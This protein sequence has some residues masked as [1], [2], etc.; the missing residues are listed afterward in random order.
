ML[1]QCDRRQ[2]KRLARLMIFSV[3]PP[4]SG[5]MATMQTRGSILPL[6][7]T[8]ALVLTGVVTGC[9]APQEPSL[10]QTVITDPTPPGAEEEDEDDEEDPGRVTRPVRPEEWL[11]LIVNAQEGRQASQM[12][13]GNAIELGEPSQPCREARERMQRENPEAVEDDTPELVELT[14]ESVLDQRLNNRLRLVW[15]VTHRYPDGDGLGPI[16]LVERRYDEDEE[17]TTINVLAAGVLRGRSLRP[18]LRLLTVREPLLTVTERLICPEPE[19][20][21]DEVEPSMCRREQEMLVAE[22]VRCRVEGRASSC[23]LTRE[24][25]RDDNVHC[26][27]EEDPQTC[28]RARQLLVAEGETCVPR[29]PE[30]AETPEGEASVDDDEEEEEEVCSRSADLMFRQGDRFVQAELFHVSGRCLGR[31]RM[32]YSNETDVELAGG[33]QRRFN[34][35]ASYEFAGAR[36]VVH[37]QVIAVDRDPTKP[38]VPPRPY[39]RAEADMHWFPFQGRFVTPN[40]SLWERMLIRHGSLELPPEAPA[41]RAAR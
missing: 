21:E 14:E 16:A 32:L 23:E 35:A 27:D 17:R 33:W 2:G 18:R 13:T 8:F 3:L 28:W 26:V 25:R 40:D 37:Q 36:M 5:K 7:L 38:E 22:G 12:C 20:G 31:A 6:L 30:E 15:V 39:R 41:E 24:L 10:C 29:E 1:I 4:S 11:Q 9:S 19:E 34:L